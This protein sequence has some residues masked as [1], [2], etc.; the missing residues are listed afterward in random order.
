V[1][2]QSNGCVL[3]SI[4]DNMRVMESLLKL[5]VSTWV[6]PAIQTRIMM[7]LQSNGCGAT[8]Q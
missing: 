7:V 5:R 3:V 4:P 8:R 2:L 6:H 1:V